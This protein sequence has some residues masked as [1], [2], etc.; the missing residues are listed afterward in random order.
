LIIYK[1]LGTSNYKVL[2]QKF[3]FKSRQTFALQR[4][5]FCALSVLKKGCRSTLGRILNERKV[6]EV[7][8]RVRN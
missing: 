2:K 1:L 3:L 8:S 5:Q 4:K 7:F 6:R